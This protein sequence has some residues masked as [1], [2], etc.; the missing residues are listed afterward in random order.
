MLK[1]A[2]TQPHVQ[3]ISSIFLATAAVS[4]SVQMDF[5]LNPIV[6]N[7][8][9]AML[10]VPYAALQESQHA[11]SVESIQ[12]QQLQFHTTSMLITQFVI[13][14]AQTGTMKSF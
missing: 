4:L 3:L 13:S 14:A 5:M 6:N 1:S 7:A 9:L 10:D 11:Q 12:F 2:S 8:P